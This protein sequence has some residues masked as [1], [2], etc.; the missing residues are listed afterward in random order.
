MATRNPWIDLPATPPYIAQIDRP[1][2][3]AVFSR[4]PAGRA[5]LRFEAL[6]HPHAGNQDKA[7]VV[8]LSLNPGWADTDPTEER[9]VPE[10]ADELRRNL[11]FEASTPFVH[12]DPRFR[13]TTGGGRWWTRRLKALAA[14][15]S[16]EPG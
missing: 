1:V 8:L 2:I 15:T 16:W 13:S 12:V 6:P 3:D 14:A 5:D 9:T 11:A 7:R 10:W 4:D